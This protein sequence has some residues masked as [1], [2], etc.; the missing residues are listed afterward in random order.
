MPLY[1]KL[2]Q[3][4]LF[5]KRG[6]HSIA[7]LLEHCHFF[8]TDITGADNPLFGVLNLAGYFHYSYL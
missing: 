7:K 1:K 3:K 4:C 6:T 5:I 8:Y 2:A